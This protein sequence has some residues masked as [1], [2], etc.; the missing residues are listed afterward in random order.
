LNHVEAILTKLRPSKNLIALV[1]LAVVLLTFVGFLT[2]PNMY[3]VFLILICILPLIRL[4]YGEGPAIK[5]TTM[6]SNGKSLA[7]SDDKRRRFVAFSAVETRT[8]GQVD[9][10]ADQLQRNKYKVLEASKILA[11][12]VGN[13]SIEVGNKGSTVRYLITYEAR[14]ASDACRRV[15]AAAERV[16][17]VIRDLYEEDLR[18]RLIEGE[19]LRSAFLSIIGGDFEALKHSGKVVV[20]DCERDGERHAF[21]I[22]VAVD[23]SFAKVELRKLLAMTRNL[24]ASITYV[25]N[26]EAR[27][28]FN[29]D[30]LIDGAEHGRTWVVSPYLVVSGRDVEVVD[31]ASIKLRND[32]EDLTRAGVL[33]IERGSSIVN[34][35]G[36]ILLRSRIH[37]KLFLSNDQLINHVFSIPSS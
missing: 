23:P 28:T 13:Y 27:R 30:V 11:E 18:P 19:Q 26:L 15:E 9:S 25:I 35:L 22:L 21:A 7:F 3:L 20:R 37:K 5:I 32:L 24:D 1:F 12:H 6:R 33:R 36:R 10:G 2:S 16:S 29:E 34:N 14:T 17:R 8:G 4:V 31:E